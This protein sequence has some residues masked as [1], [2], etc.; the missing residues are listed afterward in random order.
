MHAHRGCKPPCG[1]LLTHFWRSCLSESSP[2][3]CLVPTSGIRHGVILLDTYHTV[4]LGIDTRNK[5]SR[6]MNT[7]ALT[8][9]RLPSDPGVFSQENE[10][11]VFSTR[12]R[13]CDVGVIVSES[14]VCAGD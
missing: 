1:R 13:N 12:S 5:I 10:P 4:D 14:L 7:L 3:M 8:G 6:K 2:L 11:G 9:S